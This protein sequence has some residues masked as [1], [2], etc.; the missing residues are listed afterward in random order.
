MRPYSYT[1]RTPSRNGALQNQCGSSG[2][3][4]ATH[5]VELNHCHL[6][7]VDFLGAM[8]VD[9]GRRYAK[10]TKK[11]TKREEERAAKRRVEGK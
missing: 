6:A 11:K 3:G 5:E 7:G 1:Y 9:L 10:I 4:G 2:G 8:E